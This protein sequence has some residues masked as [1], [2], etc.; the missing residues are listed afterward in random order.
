MLNFYCIKINILS[1]TWEP[2][3]NERTDFGRKWNYLCQHCNCFVQLELTEFGNVLCSSPFKRLVS[4]T[5]WCQDYRSSF[6]HFV[7]ILEIFLNLPLYGSS[8][9]ISQW[10]TS[11]VLIINNCSLNIGSAGIFRFLLYIFSHL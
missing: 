6:L 11:L 4:K 5:E 10:H 9:L 1:S 3:R 8:K 7:M 2:W